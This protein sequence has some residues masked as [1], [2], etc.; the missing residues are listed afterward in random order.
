MGMAKKRKAVSLN[1]VY[2]RKSEV[3]EELECSR[4][5]HRGFEKVICHVTEERE[6]A[7]DMQDCKINA[8]SLLLSEWAIA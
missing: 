5:K 3:G 2:N 1:S 6:A 7:N 8:K 4:R